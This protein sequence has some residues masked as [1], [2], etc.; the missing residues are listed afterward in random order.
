ML[1]P[2]LVNKSFV[3]ACSLAVLQASHSLLHTIYGYPVM[4][5][6]LFGD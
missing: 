1:A 6:R 3:E 4:L 5:Q 2:A